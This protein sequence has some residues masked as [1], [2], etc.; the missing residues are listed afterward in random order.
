MAGSGRAQKHIST[1]T[2]FGPSVRQRSLYLLHMACKPHF[3]LSKGPTS[4]SPA[5]RM[6]ASSVTVIY[7]K[8]PISA[9]WS[10]S[11]RAPPANVTDHVEAPATPPFGYSRTRLLEVHT[12]GRSHRH[13]AA[14]ICR[15]SSTQTLLTCFLETRTSSEK[16][17][18]RATQIS[19]RW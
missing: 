8:Q 5:L 13:R 19:Q 11:V 15:R 18:K 14:Y 17:R 16:F 10:H 2:N 7:T 6:L 3:K 1:T 9:Q 4:F 12:A